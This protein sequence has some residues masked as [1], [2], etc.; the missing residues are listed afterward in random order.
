MFDGE[1]RRDIPQFGDPT[2]Y[3]GEAWLENVHRSFE[4]AKDGALIFNVELVDIARRYTNA[5]LSLMNRVVSA[6]TP[7]EIFALQVA[8]SWTHC[9]RLLWQA[10]ELNALTRRVLA[11]IVQPTPLAARMSPQ[12]PEKP[13]RAERHD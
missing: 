3:W 4:A 2:Q 8:N 7:T 10:A 9:A 6:K 11:D 12:W 5:A 1:D 13:R